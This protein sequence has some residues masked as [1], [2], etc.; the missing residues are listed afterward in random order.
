MCQ[1]IPAS[2]SNRTDKAVNAKSPNS[3]TKIRSPADGTSHRAHP[4]D[5]SAADFSV[6]LMEPIAI[7]VNLIEWEP[8]Q[9]ENDP[10]END[11]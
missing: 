7:A 10:Q 6:D 3:A 5:D 11:Q 9:Q 8:D 2:P 4:A 1:P